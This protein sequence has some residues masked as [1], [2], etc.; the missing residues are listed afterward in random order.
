MFVEQCKCE[1][2]REVAP[3]GSQHMGAGGSMCVNGGGG[4]ENASLP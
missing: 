3:I 1:T 2:Q 4:C